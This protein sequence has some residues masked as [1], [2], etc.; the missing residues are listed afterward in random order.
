MCIRDR[1]RDKDLEGYED[2][3]LDLDQEQ[4]YWLEQ[5]AIARDVTVDEVIED[6]LREAIKQETMPR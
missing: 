1:Y 2:V 3:E 4:L 5:Q 6:I